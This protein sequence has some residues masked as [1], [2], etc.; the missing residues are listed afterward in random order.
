MSNRIRDNWSHDIDEVIRSRH[1]TWLGL[2]LGGESIEEAMTSM[3]TDI[4]HICQREDLPFEQVL[5]NGRAQFE[6]EE[7]AE[8]AA[9]N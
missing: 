8:A 9:H 3:M 1:Y 4:M 6:R 7:R 2:G 5:A